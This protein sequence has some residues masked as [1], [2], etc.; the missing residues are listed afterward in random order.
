MRWKRNYLLPSC[1]DLLLRMKSRLLGLYRFLPVQLLLLHFRKYQLLLLFWIILFATIYG[2]FAAHF[3]AISLFLSPEYLGETTIVSFFLLGGATAMFAMSWHITTFIIHSNRV[4]FL[5]ATRHAFLKYCINNSLIPLSYLLTFG[6][7]AAR[8]L[9]INESAETGKIILLL[10]GFY[11]GYVAILMLSFIYFFRVDRNIL[12]IVLGNIANPSLIREIIPYDTLDREFDMVR[13]DSYLDRLFRVKAL[14]SPY[15]YNHRFLTTVLRRHHRNAIFAIIFAFVLLLL[16]GVFMEEPVLRIPAGAGFLLLFSIMM[17]VVG[18]FKYFLRSWE[19]IGWMLIVGLLSL[20]THYHVFDLYSMAYGLKYHG[21]AVPE[22]DYTH[23]KSVFTTARYEADK[24]QEIERLN[25]WKDKVSPTGGQNKRP[26]L[27]IIAASGGG[28]RSAYWTFRCLQMADSLTDGRLFQN[29]VLMSGASGGMIG[30]AYWRAVHTEF[31][32]GKIRNPYDSSYQRKIG[33]DLLNAIVFS[34]AAVDFISPFNKITVAGR[35][36]GKDRG[37]AFDEELSSVTDGL[38]GQ[39]LEDYKRAEAKGLSPM[40]IINATIINDGRKLM[41]TP[42]PVAYL[43]RAAYSADNTEPVIDAIDFC[44][45]FQYQDPLN[46]QLSSALRMSATFPIILPIVKLPSAPNMHIMDAGLR[47]N[48][49][50]EVCMRYLHTFREWMMRYAGDVIFLQIRDTRETE[51]S[52]P[53]NGNTMTS[54]I[55]DPLFSIQQKWGAFQT[56]KQTYIQDYTY[57]GFPPGKFHKIVLEY[58]P[59]SKEK[60]AA[61]NFHLTAKEKQDLLQSVYNRTNQQAFASLKRLLAETGK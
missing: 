51:P 38:L 36:Y 43:T 20:L 39:K 19:I 57:S 50:V 8:Y 61:L 52:E 27:V 31:T 58:I 17:A 26:P 25:R 33:K 13:A 47:D 22:Y 7:L 4:P 16:L 40:M 35:R 11:L 56:F 5:G 45:F 42:Q 34:L 37:Y 49:G 10:G 18:A 24:K 44:R 30:S 59:T 2:G 41:I 48:Y 12:K 1:I 46:L 29:T 14:K 6:I 23:L 55:V 53:D 60:S 3:G 21:Q 9:S 28:S 15:Q 54:M 32:A